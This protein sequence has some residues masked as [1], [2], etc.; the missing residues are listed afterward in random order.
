MNA[1]PTLF[2]RI[3]A[4]HV[5]VANPNGEELLSVDRN[6][7]HEGGTFLAFDQMRIS[8][9]RVRKPRQTLAVTD[10]YLPSTNRAREHQQP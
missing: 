3:W 1:P 8:G 7:L 10:H 2:D 4:R 6:L 9:D 5:I